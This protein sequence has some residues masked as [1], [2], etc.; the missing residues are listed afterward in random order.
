MRGNLLVESVTTSLRTSSP[1]VQQKELLS[2][3][4]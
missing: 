4:D 1:V 3:S 2:V